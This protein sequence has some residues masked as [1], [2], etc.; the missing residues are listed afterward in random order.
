MEEKNQYHVEGKTPFM[1]PD[2]IPNSFCIAL[3]PLPAR[4]HHEEQEYPKGDPAHT[5]TEQNRKPRI[6]VTQNSW[7]LVCHELPFH[8][9]TGNTT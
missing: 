8:I 5:K 2:S 9:R 7:D 6:I 4:S 3:H 1:L